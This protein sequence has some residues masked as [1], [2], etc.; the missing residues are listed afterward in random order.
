MAGT[1][2]LALAEEEAQRLANASAKVAAHYDGLKVAQKYIDI[3]ALIAAAGSIY[4]P[5]VI[6]IYA[7]KKQEGRPQQ[8][9]AKAPDPASAQNLFQFPGGPAAT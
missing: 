2:E 9:G 1:P 7:R 3:S 8:A 4:G 6:A 5:R